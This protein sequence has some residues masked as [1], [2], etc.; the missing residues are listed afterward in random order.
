VFRQGFKTLQ[1]QGVEFHQLGQGGRL[2]HY[3]VHFHMARQVP[4]DK[5]NDT[6]IKDSSVSES[7]TRWYVLHSTLGVT[8]QRN[9]GWKSIGHGYFLEDGTETDNKF[10]SNPCL[11]VALPTELANGRM[12]QVQ[13]V[14][15]GPP[16]GEEA[17]QCG[18]DKRVGRAGD[19]GLDVPGFRFPL[20]CQFRPDPGQQQFRPAG[21]FK[22]EQRAGTVVAEPAC[23]EQ[24]VGALAGRR[25]GADSHAISHQYADQ[26]RAD[27]EFDRLSRYRNHPQCDAA[28]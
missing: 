21:T 9:V 8:L 13:S 25:S 17:E 24:W 22:T 11:G 28:G 5:P 4:T 14:A 27:G 19:I 7:M 3:P 23:P 6:Y 15:P 12:A 20:G 16:K 18:S 26:Y 2:G 10:Y 1:L